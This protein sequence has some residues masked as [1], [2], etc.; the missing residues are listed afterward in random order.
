MTN[1][2]LHLIVI[3]L[4]SLSA[5]S[6]Q[7]QDIEIVHCL[8]GCPT[9]TP[10]TNKLIV[11]EVYALS[12][13]GNTKL[14]D[15][16]AYR[17]TKE[18]MGTSQDLNRTWRPDPFLEDDETLEP[19]DYSGAFDALG[20]DRGH[21]APLAS[22]A[23]TVFWRTTNYLS[24]ITP[25]KSALNQG[26]W[27]ALETAVRN[28]TYELGE[29]YVITGPLYGTEATPSEVMTLPRSDESHVVPSAYWKIIATKNG[30]TTAFLFDQETP[31]NV[32][33]CAL[34]FSRSV[35]DIEIIT[36]FGF[37]PKALHD[38]QSSGLRSKLGC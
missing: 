17:V 22:F 4:L 18:T 20:T 6:S 37:F 19:N 11:R 10:Q 12:N 3:F 30:Q 5:S 14:A 21:Q 25:Q 31:K 23:G 33:F 35:N 38:W 2:S 34:E 32:D 28:A 29:V 1:L 9:G 15:W 27:V 13:N 8:K 36:G 26:P 24:N 16:V 7:A